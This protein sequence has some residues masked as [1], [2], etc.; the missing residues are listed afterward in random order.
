MLILCIL[1][2]NAIFA[3]EKPLQSLLPRHKR[4]E[5]L[6][7]RVCYVSQPNCAQIF[8]SILV[9]GYINIHSIHPRFGRPDFGWCTMASHAR[10]HQLCLATWKQFQC[11]T[12]GPLQK[13]SVMFLGELKR[14]VSWWFKIGWRKSWTTLGYIYIYLNDLK[15]LMYIY[16]HIFYLYNYIYI[17]L[18]FFEGWMY[19]HLTRPIIQ[20]KYLD[21]HGIARYQGNKL[22]KSTQS[23]SHKIKI[24][25]IGCQP[26]LEPP[27]PC[28]L[29]VFFLGHIHELLENDSWRL[30]NLAGS[31]LGLTCG[32][33]WGWMLGKRTVSYFNN[34]PLEIFGMNL[35]YILSLNTCSAANT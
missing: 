35:K 22:L 34:F 28:A 6:M 12:W 33:G 30:L 31:C 9:H 2:R 7:N 10:S 23:G 16:I 8:H 1:A 32:H 11:W 21:G 4:M 13:S 29:P 25:H 14:H 18:A 17:Y 26:I 19:T 15:Y 5:W 20:G 3:L 24:Y 27:N